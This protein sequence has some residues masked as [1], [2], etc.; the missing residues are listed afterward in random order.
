[1]KTT[2]RDLAFLGAGIVLGVILT[3]I[4]AILI[5]QHIK[6]SKTFKPIV[7]G[8]HHDE[9]PQQHQDHQP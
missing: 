6:D 8:Q 3:I 9:S 1:M 4:P 5:S 7:L 2:V